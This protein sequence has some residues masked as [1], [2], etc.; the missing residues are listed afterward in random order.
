M[1]FRLLLAALFTQAAFF[2]FAQS[3]SLT[4]T[5]QDSSLF[6]AELNG[7]SYSDPSNI[8]NISKL[9]PGSQ[10]LKVIKLMQMGNSII[11]K[12][13]FDGQINLPAGK[14]T[15][16]Y[17]DRYNQFRINSTN[18]ETSQ[19][20]TQSNTQNNLPYFV[21]NPNAIKAY[22]QPTTNSM[23]MNNNQFAGQIETLKSINQENKR[24]TTAKGFISLGTYTS[25]QIAEMMLTLSNEHNRILLADNSY[26]YATDKENYGV[27]FNALRRPSSVRRL[28]RRLN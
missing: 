21:P 25:N 24:Y 20:S 13:V 17:I 18:A 1:M 19:Q 5:L 22:T 4:L 16:A 9:N 6:T 15:V 26:Q 23:G 14:T 11:K 10:T 7:V 2:S 3:A 28:T 27:V 12:P 8:M